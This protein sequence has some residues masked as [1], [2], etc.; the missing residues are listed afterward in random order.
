VWFQQIAEGYQLFSKVTYLS[1]RW[2]VEEKFETQ[3]FTTH[4]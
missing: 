3:L 2:V 1:E 4:S